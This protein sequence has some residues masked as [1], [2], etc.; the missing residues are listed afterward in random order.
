MKTSEVA[1]LKTEIERLHQSGSQDY[2]SLLRQIGKKSRQ[3]VRNA[4]QV[5]AFHYA[6]LCL[7]MTLIWARGV[8]KTT[9]IADYMV[10]LVDHLPRGVVNII[11]PS[12][13][14]FKKE[15]LPSLR[16]GLEM[17]GYYEGVHYFIG[18]R[19]PKNWNWDTP[20]MMPD[21]FT[22]IIYWYN[23]TIFQ[24]V[25]QDI[26]GSGRALSVDAEIIDEAALLNKAKLEATS[27]ATMRGSNVDEFRDSP[28]FGASIK[29]SSMP[30][31]QAGMWLLDDER[32]GILNPMEFYYSEFN[33]GVNLFNLRPGYVRDAE[34]TAIF[35]WLFEA[36]YL[37]KRPQLV[38]GAF[39]SLLSEAKHGYMP[40]KGNYIEH[41]DCRYD[42]GED[43]LWEGLPLILGVDWG[44]RINYMVV[45]QMRE[46]RDGVYLRAL[47]EFWALG[48]EGEIQADMV[49]KFAE[50]YKVYN[51]KRIILFCDRQGNNE[52][53]I[54]VE[55]R[56]DMFI[57]Q[58][59][60]LGWS[61]ELGSFGGANPFLTYRRFLWEN[62]LSEKDDNLLKF[63]VN[64][65]NCRNLL[66]SMQNAPT[67]TN[68]QKKITKDK[69]SE[70]P[71]S[72]IHPTQA[73]DPSDAEDHVLFG[74]MGADF[75]NSF[76][77][78]PNFSIGQK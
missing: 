51:T 35:R 70:N 23:G 27:T 60:L 33:V 34:K 65:L 15:M 7:H 20:Y 59:A 63:R 25:S 64:L 14:K 53:G 19:P 68:R 71:N 77:S 16:K 62:V 74:L 66:I 32:Q 44:A 76:N 39:Y 36:E 26:E 28:L 72:G 52:T 5:A 11:V 48:E 69:R 22:N 6:L 38:L 45:N 67:K 10:L 9:F 2:Q 30:V 78:L 24:L 61:V 54:T 58:L 73:T 31:T 49:K 46:E 1:I 47:N 56:V 57:N 41:E 37:N 55:T 29:L 40:I 13:K 3:L 21:D 17:L 75:K 18:R 4:A 50:Y 43:D 42:Y 12:Y 8:G